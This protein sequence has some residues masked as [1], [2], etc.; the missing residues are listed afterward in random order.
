MTYHGRDKVKFH[1]S[2]LWLGVAAALVTFLCLGA[3]PAFAQEEPE[4]CVWSEGSDSCSHLQ[5]VTVDFGEDRGVETYYSYVTPDVSTFYNATAG[6]KKAKQPSF[7]GHFGKFLNLSPDPVRIY[8]DGKGIGKD[9]NYI[10]DM[11]PMEASATGTFPGHHFYVTPKKEPTTILHKWTV[12][13]DVFLMIYDPYQNIQDDTQLLQ[14][15]YQNQLLLKSYKLQKDN[16]HFAQEYK[17]VTGREWIGLY[18]PQKPLAYP[19]WSANYIG[20]THIVPTQETHFTQFPSMEE[21]QPLR[22]TKTETSVRQLSQYRSD[23]RELNLTLTALSCAPRVFE[24]QHFLSSVEADHLV[25]LARGTTLSTSTTR[26]GSG[27]SR[28]DDSTRTSKNTWVYREKS[29]IIDSIYRRAA[30]LLQIDEALLRRRTPEEHP[31][32]GNSRS[33][34]EELQ[35]VH[36]DVGQQYTPH[37]DFMTPTN[38]HGTQAMRYATLILYLN[39]VEEGGETSFPRWLNAETRQQLKVTPE[40]GK[41][42]LF[43]SLLP[44]GNPD[45]RSQHAAL[46]VKKGEKYMTNLWVWDPHFH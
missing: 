23:D 15:F 5:P 44:D 29:P 11:G 38:I 37:H 26:A 28:T 40:K 12:Q 3:T 34:A 10:A 20:Q 16:L 1:G 8:W 43:Y 27:E 24:I 9:G 14:K 22:Q 2:H 18:G 19:L 21:L 30:D 7:P 6:T 13:K 45:E 39:D 42:V 25:E 17:K 33:I 46:P 4:T 32:L 36:Y 31:E 35:L 41:A